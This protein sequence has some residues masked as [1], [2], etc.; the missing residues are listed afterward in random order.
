MDTSGAFPVISEAVDTVKSNAT[1][2]ELLND[3]EGGGEAAFIDSEHPL[4]NDDG[5][6]SDD[7][8]GTATISDVPDGNGDTRDLPSTITKDRRKNRRKKSAPD[9]NK[10]IA[11]SVHTGGV[12]GQGDGKPGE[13]HAGEGGMEGG[14]GSDGA[15]SKSA[16]KGEL[17]PPLVKKK[18]AKRRAQRKKAAE[19]AKAAVLA[20]ASGIPT[21]NIVSKPSPGILPAAGKNEGIN[22]ISLGSAKKAG[23]K[24]NRGKYVR[25]KLRE[26]WRNQDSRGDGTAGRSDDVKRSKLNVR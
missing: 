6:D 20:D 13:E 10:P 5:F 4:M 21:E 23:C 17:R 7:L 9:K 3:H 24:R 18:A 12:V 26:G 2:F 25:K 8:G 22:N 11:S 1:N 15:E 14:P 19:A 16:G